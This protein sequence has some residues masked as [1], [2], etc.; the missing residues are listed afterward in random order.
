M[1]GTDG[2]LL[3][4]RAG[5]TVKLS[6]LLDEAVDRAENV[7]ADRYKDAALRRQIAEVVGIGGVKYADLPVARESS[8]VFDF[9]RML[10]LNGNTGPYLQYAVARIRSIFRKAAIEPDQARGPISFAEPAE[11][12]L[13]LRLLSFGAAVQQV[14]DT[15]E[16]H[17][18]CA[19][20][21]DLASS[22]TTFYEQCPVLGAPSAAVKESRL[23][24]SALTLRV[25]LAGLGMLGVRV[26]DRM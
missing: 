8:Y 19:Y 4:T 12:A 9:D 1:L 25:Q 14:A 18:L 15:A 2:K 6:Q 5:G 24:L 10:A 13:S 21:F 16:P 22:F 3:R 26:P 20:L 17:R 23:A 11:R 7:I